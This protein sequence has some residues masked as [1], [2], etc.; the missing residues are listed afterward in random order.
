MSVTG[1]IHSVESCGTVDGPGVRFVVFTQGCPARCLYCHNPDTWDLHGGNQISVDDLVSEIL[2][3]RSYIKSGGVTLTGGE[4]MLQPEFVEATFSACRE[5]G[6]HTALDTSGLTNWQDHKSVFDVTDLVLLDLKCVDPEIHKKLT[7]LPNNRSLAL[8]EYLNEIGKPIWIR[9]VLVPG[10]TADR[11]LL[12][13]SAELLSK[14][15]VVERVEILPFHKLGEYKWDTLG[16]D[17]KLKDT[18]VPT[19]EEVAMA[20][21]I[22]SDA[23][24]NVR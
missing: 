23:G 20:K 1:R 13:R 14:Y 22:F 15:S 6:L 19:F 2:K 5:A 7:G 11:V 21:Q 3:Y 12:E 16:I 9:H 17:F 18:P 24:F 8:L 4:P 10:I